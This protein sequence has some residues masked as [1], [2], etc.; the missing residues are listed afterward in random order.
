ME[1]NK[2]KDT[3]VLEKFK[4]KYG[5]VMTLKLQKH[6]GKEIEIYLRPI[7]GLSTYFG[8]MSRAISLTEQDKSVAAG[9]II[10]RSTYVGG[11]FGEQLKDYDKETPEFLSACYHCSKLVRVLNGNFTVT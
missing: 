1:D 4:K 3:Q 9:E 8:T 2:K 7:E 10:L 5:K 11:D 6:D